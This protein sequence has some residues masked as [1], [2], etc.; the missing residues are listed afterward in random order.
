[1]GTVLGTAR[2]GRRDVAPVSFDDLPFAEVLEPAVTAVAQD[3][4]AIGTAAAGIA[5][6][7]LDGDHSRARTVTVPT[8]LIP[9][10]SG[11]LP[12]H[13]R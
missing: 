3:P 6:A 9:R 11:E 1:M 5:L 8:R 12:P 10:G 7:R 2:A 4:V 13:D